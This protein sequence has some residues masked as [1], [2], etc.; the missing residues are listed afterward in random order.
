MANNNICN[1]WSITTF[2]SQAIVYILVS[3]RSNNLGSSY[4]HSIPS[5]HL[6]F[7]YF[8]GKKNVICVNLSSVFEK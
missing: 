1:K 3:L 7:D 2:G 5:S 4:K 6:M 8:I